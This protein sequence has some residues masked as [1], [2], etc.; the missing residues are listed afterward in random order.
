MKN[1][2]IQIERQNDRLSIS[3]MEMPCSLFFLEHTLLHVISTMEMLDSLFSSNTPC[4]MSFSLRRGRKKR[5]CRQQYKG[6][7]QKEQRKKKREEERNARLLTETFYK[8]G[9]NF[10]GIL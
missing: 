8:I 10:H 9:T 5:K 6:K 1:Q 7:S 3:A 2:G 4:N